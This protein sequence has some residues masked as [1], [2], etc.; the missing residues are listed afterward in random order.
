VSNLTIAVS[1]LNAVDSPG[2][3]VPVLRSLIEAEIDFN[4]IGLAYDVLD[5]GNFMN[6]LISASYIVPYPGSGKESLL[7]RIEY[8]LQRQRID[9]IFPTLDSELENYISIE[10]EL[11][12]LGIS[13][14]LPSIESLRLR[15]KTLLTESIPDKLISIPETIAINEVSALQQVFEKLE[16][17]AFIKGKYYD[18]Y[19]AGTYEEASGYFHRIVSHWGLPVLVQQY[20][21][22]EECNV[23]ALARN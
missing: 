10:N 9:I 12:K 16:I 11:K 17:P 20:I 23:A 7:E 18:A 5:P 22:G 6:N 15:D 3:G 1:G 4:L 13:M 2:P 21:K 8:I 14:F 19:L